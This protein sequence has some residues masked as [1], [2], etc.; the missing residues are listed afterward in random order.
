MMGRSWGKRALPG[1]C[2][3][4]L[5]CSFTAIASLYI[6][7]VHIALLQHSNLYES[8]ASSLHKAQKKAFGNAFVGKELIISACD[9]HRKKGSDIQRK[10]LQVVG[11]RRRFRIGGHDQACA[12]APQDEAGRLQRKSPEVELSRMQLVHLDAGPREVGTAGR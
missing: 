9:R 3:Y 10:L 7:G 1:L 6:H 8:I 12:E 5:A 4:Q 2:K 11:E